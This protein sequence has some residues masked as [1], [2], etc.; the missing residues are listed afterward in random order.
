[1]ILNGQGQYLDRPRRPARQSEPCGSVNGHAGGETSANP[2]ETKATRTD[3]RPRG[4]GGTLLA[5]RARTTKV[6]AV[7]VASMRYTLNRQRDQDGSPHSGGGGET[8]QGGD[9]FAEAVRR[10][11][12]WLGPLG[13]GHDPV[14]ASTVVEIVD[15]SRRPVAVVSAADNGKWALLP[16]GDVTPASVRWVRQLALVGDLAERVRRS[17]G[18]LSDLGAE[19]LASEHGADVLDAAAAR[20]GALVYRIDDMMRHALSASGGDPASRLLLRKSLDEAVEEADVDGY[21]ALTLEG[22][23]HIPPSTLDPVKASL[24]R[25]A[26]FRVSESLLR[27]CDLIE[28][29]AAGEEPA[30]SPVPGR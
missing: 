15:A 9:T 21:H 7:E 22:R 18:R 17:T 11:R 19:G 20:V 5:I 1:M 26:L 6:A 27:A 30:R 14:G 24:A 25:Q 23:I 3:G 4:D 8:R 16:A 10:A 13:P 28:A 29:H 2:P 12:E